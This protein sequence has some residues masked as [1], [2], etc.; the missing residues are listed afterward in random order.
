MNLREKALRGVFWSAVE[1]WGYQFVAIL[2]FF[3]LAR[4]LS[5]KDFG[6]VALAS[7]FISFM[8]IFLDQGF[9]QAI[10]QRKHLEAEHL[11]TAFWFSIGLGIVLTGIIFLLTEPI[12]VFFGTPQL[13][14]VIR[15]LSVSFIF[16][17]FSSVQEAILRR[18][19]D[20]K[21]I[22]M[23]TLLGTVLGGGVGVGMALMNFG[24]W[25]LVAK[26]LTFFVTACILLWS[27][28]SWRPRF[29]FSQKHFQDLFLFGVNILGLRLLSFINLRGINLLIG[30][31]LGTTALGYFTIA[32]R[33]LS[34]VIE[35][36][37]STTNQVSL[38]AFARLQDN[39]DYLRKV[40]LK[41][42]RLIG[43]VALPT[44]FLLSALAPEMVTLTFG[45]QWADSVPII[46][47]LAFYGLLQ[48]VSLFNSNVLNAIGKPSWVLGIRSLD[49]LCSLS[50]FLLVFKE[51]INTVALIYAFQAYVLF[52]LQLIAIKKII[53]IRI[54]DYLLQYRGALSGASLAS[55]SAVL[56][57]M[58]LQSTLPEVY[59]LCLSL[60]V[61]IFVYILI[62]LLLD[63]GIIIESRKIIR[64]LLP[65][66]KK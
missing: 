48:S 10:I 44:F 23:R 25:S 58:L 51:G 22:S 47:F 5:P 39:L 34:I 9:A 26:E 57:K 54:L 36:L 55:I 13:I 21:A 52:P 63:P 19:L 50:L 66:A 2:V 28:S 49:T 59:I 12:A 27:I 29:Q 62:I 8:E 17:S 32:N 1:K 4:L 41:V 7:V 56:V 18:N 60:L 31:F 45:N 11:D 53:G 24:I 16:R 61:A 20:F 6:L 40:F 38:S 64:E 30:Y 14:S 43:L 65:I 35:I 37:S 3:L 33:I 46:Q 15:W 42:T